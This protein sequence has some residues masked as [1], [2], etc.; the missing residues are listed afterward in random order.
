MDHALFAIRYVF[1]L[2]A[3]AVTL[4]LSEIDSYAVYTFSCLLFVTLDSFYYRWGPKA[5]KPWLV[6][7][8][9]ALVAYLN[10]VYGGLMFLLYFAVL[11]SWLPDH[12]K[13]FFRTFALLQLALL[14]AA[15]YHESLA[16]L[17]LA[18]LLYVVILAAL[19]LTKNMT[20]QREEIQSLYDSQ[21]Q[22]VYELDEARKRLLEYAQKVEN[23]AQ[24]EER[25]RISKEIHDELGHKLI[26]TKLMM[27]AAIQVIP[28]DKEKG[29]DMLYQIR[30][31]LSES[32]ETLRTTVRNLKPDDRVVRS[33]SI[34]QLVEDFTKSSGVQ[35][36]V[37][38][39]GEPFRQYPSMEVALYRNAQEALTNAV[40]H[41]QARHI[42]VQLEYFPDRLEM[43]VSNDGRLPEGKIV[44]GLGLQGME[45]RLSLFG[46]TVDTDIAGGR[47]RFDYL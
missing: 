32:M 24:I 31:Q 45:E 18:N 30:D 16:E 28:H 20:R 43:S 41:G 8:Q 5:I 40:R 6:L 26:R 47:F 9:I 37:T 17:V 39:R 22:N 10:H 44:K 3:I 46:G 35:V 34:Q 2:M 21:R 13:W 12:S 14:N 25:N 15:L 23:A 19:I 42:A 27:E 11:F 33:F 7:L 29:M 38:V 4:Y 36:E 1:I